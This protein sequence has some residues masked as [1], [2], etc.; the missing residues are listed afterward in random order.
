MIYRMET[1]EDLSQIFKDLPENWVQFLTEN[2]ANPRC[3]IIAEIDNGLIGYVVA[4]NS[5]VPPMSNYFTVLLE[6]GNSD[7]SIKVL[8]VEA[9]RDGAALIVKAAKEHS[10]EM[11][12][13]GWI[14]ESVNLKMEL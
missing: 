11:K 4:L 8:K 7:R 14:Q 12:D 3:Y 10:Q 1:P 13:K 9:R 2:C 5:V 6:M